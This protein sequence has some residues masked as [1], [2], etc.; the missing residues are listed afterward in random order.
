MS[1]CSVIG[2]DEDGFGDEW[3]DT[4][5]LF[6]FGKDISRLGYFTCNV[7]ILLPRFRI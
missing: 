7:F 3:F 4:E 6:W 5:Y 2:I 1:L